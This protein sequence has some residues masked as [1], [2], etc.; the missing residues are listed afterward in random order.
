M[1]GCRRQ[2]LTE[3]GRPRAP[4]PALCS[5]R[6]VKSRPWASRRC[7]RPG[8]EV[9]GQ[10]GARSAQDSCP[11]G[12]STGCGTAWAPSPPVGQPSPRL[13]LHPASH[14]GA[15]G[16]SA[17]R[18]TRPCDP[19]SPSALVLGAG[20]CQT[21]EGSGKGEDAQVCDGQ[22]PVRHPQPPRVR[23]GSS[24]DGIGVSPSSKAREQPRAEI[25]LGSRRGSGRP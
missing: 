22:G 19:C 20:A 17:S 2:I 10:V 23:Q 1:R 21:P 18:S 5:E 7:H 11:V 3:L 25:I 8:A 6:T 13:A 24:A 15:C 16:S 14:P 9:P 4:G 12:S